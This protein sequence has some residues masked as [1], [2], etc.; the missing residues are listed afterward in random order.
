LATDLAL[1]LKETGLKEI[2]Y[3]DIA[4]DGMLQGPNFESLKEIAEVSQ[5]RVIASGGVTTIDDIKKL[6]AD[7]TFAA[8]VGKAIYSGKLNLQEAIKVARGA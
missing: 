3:T 1:K 2:L 7:G 4:K 8:I 6:K 5:M